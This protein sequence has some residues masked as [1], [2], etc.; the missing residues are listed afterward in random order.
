MHIKDDL[1]K[2]LYLSISKKEIQAKIEQNT[3]ICRLYK[4]TFI[5]GNYAAYKAYIFGLRKYKLLPYTQNASRGLEKADKVL[6][7]LANFFPFCVIS[8]DKERGRQ[9]VLY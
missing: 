8:R 1:S 6:I 7:A 9:K 3:L 4:W 5:L 2:H